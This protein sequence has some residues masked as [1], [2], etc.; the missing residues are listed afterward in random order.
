MAQLTA[1]LRMFRLKEEY[2]IGDFDCGNQDLNDFLLN[3]AKLFSKYL[4]SVTYIIE[5]RGDVVAFFSLSND[6]ISIPDSDK[7]TWRKIKSKFPHRKHRSDY[8]AVKIGR[9]GVSKKYQRSRIGSVILNA[10]RTMYVEEN[11]AGCTFITVDALKEAIPFYLK[12]G[13][14]FLKKSEENDGKETSLLYFNLTSLS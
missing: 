6:K 12:N 5:R 4:L 7:S 11:R 9:L 2:V 8:P 1:D 14:K 13:F 10:V 3:E